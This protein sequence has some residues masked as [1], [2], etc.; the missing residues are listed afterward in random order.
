[1][2]HLAHLYLADDSPEARIGNLLGDFVKGVVGN[3]Y[4]AEIKQGIILHRKTDAF[5]DSHFRTKSSRNLIRAPRRRFAGIIVD[6]CYDHFLSRHWSRYS[7]I[8]LPEF[9]SRVY[10]VLLE[11]REILPEKLRY[12]LPRLIKENWLSAWQNLSGVEKTLNRISARLKRRNQ[13]VGAMEEIERNYTRLEADFL[14]FFPDLVVYARS[15]NAQL[16]AAF[17]AAKEP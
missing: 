8:E 9:A 12:M 2:N 1:M 15:Y 5:T 13:L 3:Q 16:K 14:A 4:P 11:H 17:S 7:R 6:V 10:D